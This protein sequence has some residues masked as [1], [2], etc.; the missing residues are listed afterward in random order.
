MYQPKQTQIIVK[1]VLTGE[2]V[3]VSCIDENTPGYQ[4]FPPSPKPSTD[5]VSPHWVMKVNKK[6]GVCVCQRE[7]LHRDYRSRERTEEKNWRT[8]A[9]RIYGNTFNILGVLLDKQKGLKLCVA[10]GLRKQTV[11]KRCW[12]FLKNCNS[13]GPISQFM[14]FSRLAMLWLLNLAHSWQT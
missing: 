13:A 5:L 12:Y 9:S 7:R 8:E 4:N 3:K 1:V 2:T 14:T 10:K 11:K 6:H